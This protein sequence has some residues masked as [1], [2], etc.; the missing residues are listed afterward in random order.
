MQAKLSSIY[1]V[2]LFAV[3]SLVV[4]SLGVSTASTFFVLFSRM[5][6]NGYTSFGGS[7]NPLPYCGAAGTGGKVLVTKRN[8]RRRRGISLRHED[9]VEP[10]IGRHGMRTG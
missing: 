9:Q 7:A 2:Y 6:V 5:D 4:S 1:W 3:S 8:R 10:G